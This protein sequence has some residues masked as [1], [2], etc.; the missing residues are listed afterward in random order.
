MD[1]LLDGLLDRF[2]VGGNMYGWMG[3]LAGGCGWEP[4]AGVGILYY[5][6]IWELW[7]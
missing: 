5:N 2:M 1:G 4:C 3:C 6:A 7:S